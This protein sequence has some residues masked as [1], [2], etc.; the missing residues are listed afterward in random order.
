MYSVRLW[1]HS[2]NII[3]IL[4]SQEYAL[5]ILARKRNTEHCKNLFIENI[6]LTFSSRYVYTCLVHIKARLYKFIEKLD[7]HLYL[8]IVLDLVTI[9]MLISV[10]HPGKIWVWDYL[11]YLVE[12]LLWLRNHFLEN[13]FPPEIFS[14]I[15][16]SKMFMVA[17]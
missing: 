5:Y 12:K 4:R 9:M 17:K 1:K 7:I 16:W 8:G 10:I 14:K 6:I 2:I 11:I 3:K 13:R 15:F